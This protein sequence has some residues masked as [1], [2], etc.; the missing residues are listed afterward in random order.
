[1]KQLLIDAGNSSMKWALLDKGV[2]SEMRRC[3]YEDTLPI[4]KYQEILSKQLEA[5]HIDTVVIVSVLGSSFIEKAKKLALQSS[6]SFIGVKSLDQLAGVSNAYNEPHKLG[7]DRLVAMIGAHNLKDDLLN[8][9]SEQ[10]IQASIVVDSGTA[11]TIDAID[12][13]GQHLGGLILPGLDLCSQS[14]LTLTELL[15]V[16][17]KS[18]K[19]FEP[20]LFSVDTKQAIASGSFFGLSGA[21]NDV[22][23]KMEKEIRRDLK[24]K[25][26]IR[27]LI[28]GGAAKQLLPQLSDDFLIKEDIIM[29]GLKIISEF[30]NK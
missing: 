4:K 16:F 3:M 24:N 19:E 12:P 2:L 23:S 30:E 1:M 9:T 5:F 8:S 13:Y 6:V 29:Q 25:M 28:C 22:C 7:A 26:G 10:A 18:T 17:S 15:P 27:K 20:K 21:I 11:T 14:L